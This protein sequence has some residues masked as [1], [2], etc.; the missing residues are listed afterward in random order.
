[1]IGGPNCDITDA[2]ESYYSNSKSLH[3][4]VN[5]E[6]EDEV[7]TIP[8]Y[9]SFIEEM[10]MSNPVPQIMM[11]FERLSQFK[12]FIRQY[13]CM[14]RYDIKYPK[15][16]SDKSICVCKVDGCLFRAYASFSQD[17]TKYILKSLRSDHNC[18]RAANNKQVRSGLIARKYLEFFKDDPNFKVKVLKVMMNRDLS[19]HVKIMTLCRARNIA[20]DEINDNDSVVTYKS[21]FITFYSIVKELV[22]GCR[23]IIGMDRCHLKS[24]A[25]GC[26]LA[27]IARDGNNQMFPIAYATGRMECKESWLWFI[28]ALMEAIVAENV[29]GWTFITDRQKVNLFR[30]SLTCLQC[31]YL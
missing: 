29:A 12:D 25:G 6:D 3:M 19:V 2:V 13:R 20:L 16:D 5:S 4:P 7:I 11:E 14:R 23:L 8:K 17:K 18:G 24:I 10:D 26:L 9:P 22:K 28:I 1:M 15:N 31:T 30:L 21:I 27:A